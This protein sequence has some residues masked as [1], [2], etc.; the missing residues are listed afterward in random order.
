MD[1]ITG[2]ILA[3]LAAGVTEG[4]AADAYKALKFALKRKFGAQ[5]KVVEAVNTLEDE[6]D[7]KPNQ[8]ALAGRVEQVNAAQDPELRA[9]AERLVAALEESK[10]GQQA[11]GKYNIQMKDSQV[12]VIGNNARIEGGIRFG[13]SGD[14]I[15]ISDSDFSGANVNIRSKLKDVNQ[16]I[17]A[18]SN[19]DPA[20]KE[21]L[22]KLTKALNDALQ[23]A[24]ADKAEDTE[25]VA[26]YAEMLIDEAGE[27]QPNKRMIQVTG[28][29][30]KQAAQ[31]LASVVPTVLSI[32]TQIVAKVT[33]L[34]ASRGAPQ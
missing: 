13:S 23:Q 1:P 6:P 14:T 33:Q 29:G 15:T 9:L 4:L 24:P 11:L 18:L 16:T 19:T 21:E 25:T 34:V 2:A 12:G 28:E 8:A 26:H 17:G 31:N 5:S 3:A 10:A 32:A 27:E 30:L 7:F 22:K 20:L